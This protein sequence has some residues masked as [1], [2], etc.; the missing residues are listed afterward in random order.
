M[1]GADRKTQNVS[2]LVE[3]CIRDLDTSN[4][5]LISKEEFVK[6]LI[7]INAIRNHGFNLTTF[8]LSN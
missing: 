1:L 3:E 8:F 5:G 2:A 6:G 7:Y 4:D